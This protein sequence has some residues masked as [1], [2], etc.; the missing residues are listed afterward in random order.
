MVIPSSYMWLVY[1]VFLPA[2]TERLLT[3][4]ALGRDFK[5]DITLVVLDLDRL[6]TILNMT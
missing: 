6:T 4:A 2:R 1:F 5:K 3:Q